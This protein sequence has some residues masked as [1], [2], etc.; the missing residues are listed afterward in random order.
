MSTLVQRWMGRGNTIKE[1]YT[2]KDK[3]AGFVDIT[4]PVLSIMGA[5]GVAASAA[6]AYRGFPD[7]KQCLLGLIA[8]FITFA[9]IH[10]FND[11][12]DSRRDLTCWPGRPLPSRRLVSNQ[13][14]IM[15]LG[16]FIAA[17]AIVWWTFNPLCFIVCTLAV[18]LGCLYSAYLRDKVGYL[19][20][21]PI[22]SILWLCG[23]TAFSPETLFSTGLPWVLYLFSVIWQAGHI[24][25]YSPL[26]PIRKV[27]GVKLTQV[28]ALFVTTSPKTAA[29]L[30]FIFYCLTLG[31]GIFLGFYANLGL[32]YIIPVCV[33]GIFVL[34]VTYKFMRDSENFR[35]GINAFQ[36]LTYFMLVARIFILLS[37]FLFF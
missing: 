22:Q 36:S 23:W 33:M 18:I 26:H 35:K 32:L 34:T 29:I 16:A 1:S 37:V 19:I 12:V 4:R 30:G 21:P 5:L 28:P 3:L 17:L 15:T 9:G 7:W 14:L 10:T 8:A 6:L 20:L 27:K 31:L 25:V 24:M 13:A 2:F 11:Y